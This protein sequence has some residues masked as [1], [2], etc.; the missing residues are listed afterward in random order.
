MTSPLHPLL[1]KLWRDAAAPAQQRAEAAGAQEQL[2]RLGSPLGELPLLADPLTALTQAPLAM[3]SR[4]GLGLGAALAALAAAPPEAE[5]DGDGEDAATAGR[6]RHGLPTA[7]LAAIPSLAGAAM[8]KALAGLADPHPPRRPVVAP[9]AKQAPSR[10]AAEA[11]ETLVARFE[12]AGLGAAFTQALAPAGGHSVPFGAAVHAAFSEAGL[13]GPGVPR[14]EAASAPAG[15]RS[16]A[17]S[18]RPRAVNVA[19]ASGPASGLDRIES[20]LELLGKGPALGS[21]LQSLVAQATSPLGAGLGAGLGVGL[22]PGLG[23]GLGSTMSS[24][25]PGLGG[26]RQALA[27][28]MTSAPPRRPRAAEGP[29]R[30]GRDQA[31]AHEV[32]Q[33]AS[34]AAAGAAG[35]GAGIAAGMAAAASGLTGLRGLAARAA[36]ASAAAASNAPAAASPSA[37]AW[38]TAPTAAANDGTAAEARAGAAAPCPAA[39]E[40]DEA[41]LERLARALRREAERDGI[42]LGAVRS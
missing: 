32:G 39:A 12:R 1:S 42:D 9:A 20:L 2:E 40:S 10:A 23:T 34:S 18:T 5:G 35:L 13:I 36:A 24:Q 33:S 25:F 11:Q 7:P 14:A 29:V 28:A 8:A 15:T 19:T 6:R 37:G 3:G 31:P 16:T 22:A 4:A 26:A 41:L 21:A 17:T 27:D 30:D 38:T